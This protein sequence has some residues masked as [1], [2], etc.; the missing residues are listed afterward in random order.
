MQEATRKRCA[1]TPAGTTVNLRDSRDNKVYRVRKMADGNCW[2]V[3]NL[4]FDLANPSAPTF[5][6]AAALSVVGVSNVDTKAQ[7]I[8]NT[9]F[10]TAAGQATYLYNW[11][12]ALGDTSANCA[13]SVSAVDLGTVDAGGI[14]NSTGSATS[15]PEVVGICPAPFRLPKGGPDVSVVGT[16]NEFV[17]LDI[18]MGGT[19]TYRS[20]ANTYPDF[21]STAAT[22]KSWAGV[23]SEHFRTGIHNQGVGYWWTS[24]ASSATKSYGLGLTSSNSAV[25]I[26]GAGFGHDKLVGF[27]VRCTL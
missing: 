20:N 27:A 18:S 16:V 9:G 11:C 19:G 12:A 8:A 6:P 21:M 15:Q 25:N 2:M 7:Y 17:R 1:V 3:E 14:L 23:L 26:T 4:A 13:A 10:S 5:N 24:T 22:D